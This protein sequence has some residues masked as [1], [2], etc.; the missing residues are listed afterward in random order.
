ME[1]ASLS[2]AYVTKLEK[3]KI[4]GLVNLIR[5]TW[6]NYMGNFDNTYLIINKRPN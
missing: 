6:E 5:F 2:K 1:N 3:V 4:N